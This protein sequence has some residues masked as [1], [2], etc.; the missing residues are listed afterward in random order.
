MVHIRFAV[1]ILRQLYAEI[2]P[3]PYLVGLLAAG[4]ATA[5]GLILIL[6]LRRKDL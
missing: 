3:P 6:R 4:A 1:Q 2:S 5:I